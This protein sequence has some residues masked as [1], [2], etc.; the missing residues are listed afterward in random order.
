M[1]KIITGLMSLAIVAAAGLGLWFATPALAATDS[2]REA[3]CE[4]IKA[5]G[6]KCDDDP[7]EQINKLISAIIDIFSWIIGVVAVIMVIFGGFQYVTSGG[8]ASKA[9]KGRSTILYALI[10]LVIVALAQVIVAF[11]LDAATQ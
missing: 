4:G 9:A 2:N 3:V 10:G 8:D 11:V 7:S 6:G 1:K 5:T